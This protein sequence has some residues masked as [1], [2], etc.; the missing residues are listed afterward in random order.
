MGD[1]LVPSPLLLTGALFGDPVMAEV[2]SEQRAVEGW[3]AV[4]AA[5]AR[6]QAAAGVL[7]HDDAE[8]IA[9]AAVPQVVDWELLWEQARNVGYPILPLVRM[10]AAALPDGPDGRVHYGAT[11]QDIMDTALAL[12]LTASLDRIDALLERL[13]T[14]LAGHVRTHRDTVM[15]A[16]THGQQAVPTTFGAKLAVYLDELLRHRERTAEARPRV[17]RVSLFGA[18]GTSAALG[19]SAQAVREAMA[20]QLG[21]H[22]PLAPWHVARDG[23]AEFGYLCALVSGTCARLAS[24][25]VDLSRTEI[26]E[27]REASGHHRGASSTMP[28]KV[29]PIGSEAVIGLATTAGALAGALGRTLEAGHERAAGEWQLEWQVLPQ[30]A[31]LAAGALAKAAEVVEGLRV[32]PAAMERNLAADGGLV[33]AE[34][35]MMRL[36]PELGRERAHDLIYEAAGEARERGLRLDEVLDGRGPR[37]RPQ[38]YLGE[39]GALCDRVLARWTAEEAG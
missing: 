23:P 11:T 14:A 17:G 33:M 22:P 27:L 15:A 32:D 4:E 30:L 8:A 29:N 20:E 3:L 34:A 13:G 21:L 16:R 26:G 39:C 19:E 9:R 10:V 35:Y 38:D 6:A 25:V 18:G 31:C 2:F 12:Q 36:A 1:Q 7:S 28:Q 37:L 24:E 5:L